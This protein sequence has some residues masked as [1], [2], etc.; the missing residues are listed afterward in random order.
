MI[1]RRVILRILLGLLGVLLLCVAALFVLAH[2]E[3]PERITYGISFNTPYARELGLD[4]RETYDAFLDEL[5]V[6]HLR[7]AAH[8]DMVEPE[9]DA[10]QF[11]ELDYQIAR[12]EEVGADV[13]FG[14]GRRL[15]RWPECHIPGW[16]EELTWEEQKEEIREYIRAVVERYKDSSAITYW[17]VENEPYLT[18]FAH[19]HCGDLDEAFLKEEVALVRSLDSTRPIL[20]TDSGNLGTWSGA[21]KHGDA[22]GTSVYVY[23]W[24]PEL[25]QFKTV[26]PPWFYRVK[27]GLVELVYGEKPTFLIELAAEP[28]LLEPI[29][30]V[31]IE[32][33]FSRMN[34]DKFT[35]ILRYARHTRLERQYLWG[36][37]WWY[38]LREQGHPQM[39]ERGKTL[40]DAT[41]EDAQLP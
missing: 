36:G 30:E 26:L 2:K 14:V 33:Q 32:T 23:F 15:P 22:F 34:I 11:D 41:H 6:R 16:A 10:Y 29:T 38:W 31:D 17:Q 40:F 18:V 9:R 25:G 5:G 3:R 20:L 24:N 39:W 7:L 4:P 27:E 37:E 28:W 19:S 13:V 21:Y 8:W 35:E 12:A 1:S